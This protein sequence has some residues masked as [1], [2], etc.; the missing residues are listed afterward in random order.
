MGRGGW[1]QERNLY[2]SD[3]K[4]I[5][6]KI[7]LICNTNVTKGIFAHLG[8]PRPQT[9]GVHPT[10]GATVRAA[11]GL[12]ILLTVHPHLAQRATAA[13]GEDAACVCFSS[14]GEAEK[15]KDSKSLQRHI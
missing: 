15:G 12:T 9:A 7:V 6:P 2:S 1:D 3:T 10:P 14:N 8:A 4:F 5:P 13:S 11:H